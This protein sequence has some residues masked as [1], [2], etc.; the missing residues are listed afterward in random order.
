MRR[1]VHI[2]VVI[3]SAMHSQEALI[4]KTLYYI[5]QTCQIIRLKACFIQPSMS[6]YFVEVFARSKRC[7]AQTQKQPANY[8]T[9]VIWV[10]VCLSDQ[11]T[12]D[13]ISKFNPLYAVL[14]YRLDHLSSGIIL[15][16]IFHTLC[17]VL[18]TKDKKMTY[19]K[20]SAKYV[21]VLD[22]YHW[23]S[24]WWH[25]MN[26]KLETILMHCFASF[27]CVGIV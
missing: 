20:C 14:D 19:P 8:Q 12:Q 4:I 13:L 27:L 1:T 23:Q 22:F 26:I 7:C 11:L 18:K 17:N 3:R 6:S 15:Q 25:A 10:L 2:C 21:G 24:T 9:T 5:R 16:I